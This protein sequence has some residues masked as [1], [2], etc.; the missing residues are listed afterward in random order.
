M[1]LYDCF[2]NI[3]FLGVE[4]KIVALKK[5]GLSIRMTSNALTQRDVVLAYSGSSDG[6]YRTFKVITLDDM[7]GVTNAHALMG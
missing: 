4:D 7:H 1:Q 2:V 6:T 3:T 5:N